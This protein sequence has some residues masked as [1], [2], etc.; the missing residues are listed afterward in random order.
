MGKYITFSVP[1]K[2]INEN[3]KLVTCKLKFVD[4]YIFMQASLSKLTDNL[5][6]IN[7]K[8]CNKN[9]KK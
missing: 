5:S 3:D 6:E 1:L 2:K 4:S 9:G 7:N 8:D